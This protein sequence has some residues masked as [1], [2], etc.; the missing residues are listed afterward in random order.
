MGDRKQ[1]LSYA[2][3]RRNAYK[4]SVDPELIALKTICLLSHTISGF[5][6]VLF[7][8]LEASIDTPDIHTEIY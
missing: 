2:I 3:A 8:A 4:D 1:R 6:I 5:A 7:L